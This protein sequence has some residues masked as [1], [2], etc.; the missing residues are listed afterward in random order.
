MPDA[1]ARSSFQGTPKATAV[2]GLDGTDG[3]RAV[4]PK[5]LGAVPVGRG[6]VLGRKSR[7]PL[8]SGFRSLDNPGRRTV[9]SKSAP[10]TRVVGV[11]IA[12]KDLASCH[13]T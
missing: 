5:G 1:W 2:G 10:K 11:F 9:G 12:E 8:D 3:R 6:A 7:G 13:Y 4:R